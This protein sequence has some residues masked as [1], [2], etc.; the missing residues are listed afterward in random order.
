MIRASLKDARDFGE[1]FRRHHLTIYSYAVKAVGPTDGPDIAAEA[2]VMA[3]RIRHRYNFAYPSASPWLHGIAAN[4][5]ARYFRTMSR[6]H[7]VLH[8]LRPSDPDASEFEEDTIGRIDASSLG[9]MMIRAMGSLRRE[10]AE[11]VTLFAVAGLSYREISQALGIPEGTVR[12]RLSRARAR[13]RNLLEG[14]GESI[15]GGPVD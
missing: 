3:L 4:L 15:G 2:F 12:S 8:R 11:I 13:L 9:P 1:I 7:R 6:Q 5:V 14:F 10:E